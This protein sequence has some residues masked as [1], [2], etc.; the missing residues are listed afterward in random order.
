MAMTL[1]EKAAYIKGLKEGLTLDESKPEV[2][3]INAL[4]DIID[5]LALDVSDLE[6]EIALPSGLTGIKDNTSECS[7]L[8]MGGAHGKND[9][10]DGLF[11][12]YAGGV[13]YENLKVEEKKTTFLK[14]M[15][16]KRKQASSTDDNCVYYLYDTPE[17]S[18][19]EV[20]YTQNICYN[21]GDLEVTDGVSLTLCRS[22]F[23]RIDGSEQDINE[24]C[25][26]PLK[27]VVDET[28]GVCEDDLL[29]MWMDQDCGIGFA[30]V[31]DWC[32][33]HDVDDDDLIAVGIDA[34]HLGVIFSGA[35]ALIA[36][37]SSA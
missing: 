36:G 29:C 5:D 28:D 19:H 31:R 30:T 8:F 4:I 18:D 20:G 35:F 34:H 13:Q 23:E 11:K 17:G 7:V 2:K 24:G 33:D 27:F 22:N 14:N 9:N 16:F 6:D 26:A 37:A 32:E 12:Y 3:L 10:F 25:L 1:T 15:G 21:D